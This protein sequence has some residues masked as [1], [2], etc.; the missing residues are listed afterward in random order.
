MNWFEEK[1]V[2]KGNPEALKEIFNLKKLDI[3]KLRDRTNIKGSSIL[4]RRLKISVPNV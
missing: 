2:Q 4:G 1:G 3:G